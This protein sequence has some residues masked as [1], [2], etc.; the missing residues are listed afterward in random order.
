MDVSVSTGNKYFEHIILTNN[1][2]YISSK[3]CL[4]LT[5]II[6]KVLKEGM[7]FDQKKYMN[8]IIDSVC[9]ESRTIWATNF[10]KQFIRTRTLMYRTILVL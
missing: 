1:Y 4:E 9:I 8:K 5:N 2:V 3:T 6:K 7:F 10:N